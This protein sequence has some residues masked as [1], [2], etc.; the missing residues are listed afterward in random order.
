MNTSAI[1]EVLKLLTTAISMLTEAKTN[2]GTKDDVV[3]A[4]LDEAAKDLGQAKKKLEDGKSAAEDRELRNL[5]ILIAEVQDVAERV[6]AFGTR[7]FKEGEGS[8]R[9]AVTTPAGTS[10]A[11]DQ[12]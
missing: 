11:Q 2:V 5:D 12:G 4:K 10:S 6:Q 9:N 8:G 7:F 3:R 1:E